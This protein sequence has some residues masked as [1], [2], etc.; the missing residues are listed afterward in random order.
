MKFTWVDYGPAYFDIV[1]SWLDDEARRE[2]GFDDGGWQAYWEYYMHDELSQLGKNFWCKVILNGDKPFAAIALFLM[3][4]GD[5]S[6]PE[7]I[8]APDMRNQGYGSAA[9]RELLEFGGEILGQ[10]FISAGTVIFPDNIASQKAFQKAGLKY[11]RS[12]PDD[13]TQIYVYK[14]Q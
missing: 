10:E 5:L 8:V 6:I 9:L 1:D 7:Y 14:K 12:F 2:L 11:D 4:N 13:G 3:D